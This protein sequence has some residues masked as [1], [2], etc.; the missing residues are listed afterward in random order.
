LTERRTFEVSKDGQRFL[1][2]SVLPDASPRAVS[3]I[4]GWRPQAR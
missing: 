1:F 4:L 3:V 2:N